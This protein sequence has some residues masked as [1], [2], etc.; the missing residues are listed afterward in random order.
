MRPL[1]FLLAVCILA[2]IVTRV[3][4][5][6]VYAASSGPLS[7]S[8]VVDDSSVG[9]ITW[10]NPGNS[11]SSDNA[12]AIATLDDLQISHYLKVT[13]FGFSIPSNASIKGVTVEIEKS[14]Q[15]ASR[16]KDS[17]VKI[18]KG[19]SIGTTNKADTT[20]F[21]STTDGYAPY[22]GSSDLWGET[23]SPSDINSSNFG[24][25]ISAKK[26]EIAGA[27]IDARIDHA[28]ITVTYNNPP[29]AVDDTATTAEDT[30]LT[31][32][33]TATSPL[34]TNDSDA[35]GDTLSITAVGN[36]VNGSVLL[37][38][39]A[40]TF[41]PSANYNGS[42]ATF[43]YTVSDGE[44]TDTGLVTVTVTAVNDAPTISV[45][46]PNGGNTFA[47]ASSQTIT[48]TASDV[49]GDTLTITLEYTTDGVSYTSIAT[50]E[51]NDSSFT[52]T[53]PSIDSA[54]VKIRATATDTS[55]AS[56]NDLSNSNFTIDSTAPTGTVSI[57]SAATYTN[58]TSVT[59][60]FT[61]SET[62]SQM[63]LRNGTTGSFQ[64]P[65]PY[66]NPH[67]YTKM[68]S[69][70]G[71]K[72]VAVRFT[73]SAGNKSVGAINDSII[74]D[75]ASPTDPTSV[76]STSHTE[77]TPSSDTTIDMSWNAGTDSLSGVD[78]YSYS[79]TQAAS[80][81][82]DTIKDVE[83]T[84]TT[85]T[86]SALSD[87]SWY[88]H[89]R[90]RDNAGNWTST[91]HVGPFV[92]D[93]TPPTVDSPTITPFNF[94]YYYIRG[95]VTV[96]AIFT[97]SASTVS[98]VDFTITDGV[99]TESCSG[100]QDSGDPTLWSC[101][102]NTTVLDDSS[103]SIYDMEITAQDSLG[104]SMPSPE[105][106]SNFDAFFDIDN[107]APSDPTDVESS[108]HTVN[109]PSTDTTI[110]MTWVEG[111]DSASGV[112]GY[113]YVFNNSSTSACDQTKD[114]EEFV[115]TVTSSSLADG[116]WYFHIC[117]VDNV[118]NWTS[119]VTVGPFIIDTTVPTGSWSNPTSGQT[120]SGIVGIIFSASDATSGVSSVAFSY[121]LA[122]SSG[123]FTAIDT[124]LTSPYTAAWDT[125]SLSLDTYTLRAVV[126]DS[127]GFSTTVDV[128]VD[129][130]TVISQ[131]AIG[132][133][134]TNGI[135]VTWVT[136]DPTSSRV[137]YD[138]VSHSSLGEAPNYGY[139]FSTQTLNTN[140]KVTSHSVTLSGLSDGTAYYYRTV[141]QGSP[142]AIGDEQ[143]FQT[144]TPAGL[145][146]GGGGDATAPATSS[147][148]LGLSSL[149][150]PIRGFVSALGEVIV[151]EEHEEILGEEAQTTPIPEPIVPQPKFPL[152]ALTLGLIAGAGL[153]ILGLLFWLAKRGL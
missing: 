127:V 104:N 63:E 61:V 108:D 90:T 147:I 50:G 130:A 134:A 19:G 143:N 42:G 87:G 26:D 12:R 109:T 77:S 151:E 33:A 117:T 43:E 51:T 52:W 118:G 81:V 70:D 132:S 123:S 53:V 107:T 72:T 80:T 44:L 91:V 103:S 28:R 96:S 141:S 30:V 45:A 25:V 116:S 4:W 16:I 89:L 99:N 95:T 114:L 27:G 84:T 38:G 15:T 122:S 64:D 135:I 75:T 78:G 88:F 47:G 129:V 85:V 22:G 94:D 152:N 18:V 140:P 13:N 145:S 32:D 126:T 115:T 146:S 139:R 40:I 149:P 102:I 86:S 14:A 20:N 21:W 93:T 71:T 119:T 133:L 11:T 113:A 82:P 92:I 138:T 17:E 110:T 106:Y 148:V 66:E 49:D 24:F 3:F 60:T 69:G 101:S 74:L 10:T 23:W 46:S 121:R 150:A 57:N 79:F 5:G 137:I 55:A 100:V 7:P 67:T 58:T 68:P 29:V 73:D 48:W 2:G 97:D 1:A 6:A 136:D 37:S 83:E 54:T 56:A 39:G 144:L 142:I 41:T 105:L 98:S 124:D 120:V 65:I 8:T 111:D 62:I 31:I 131:Q 125:S 36:P 112:D 153:V 76:S 128:G 35:D 9:T 34:L 59:L